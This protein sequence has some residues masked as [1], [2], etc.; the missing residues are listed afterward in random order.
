MIE[1][2]CFANDDDDNDTAADDD[3][4]EAHWG[5]QTLKKRIWKICIFL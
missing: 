3:D 1:K 4:D 5:M 2:V